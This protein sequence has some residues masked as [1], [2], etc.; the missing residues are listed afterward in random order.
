MAF[1]IKYLSL[2]KAEL[3]YEVE[4]RGG[5]GSTVQELRRQIVK[6]SQE[7]PSEDILESHLEPSDDLKVV[8]ESLLKSQGNLSS[9]KSKFDKNLLNRTETLLNHLYHRLNRI[10]NVPEVTDL[11][12]TCLTSFNAQYKELSA[13]KPPTSQTKPTT[14]N[15]TD[16]ATEGPTISVTCE[17]NLSSDI[18]K[19]KYSG[20]SCV[21]SFILKVEEFVLSRGI[22]YD[23]IL[24]LAFEIFTDDALHWYR[25]NKDK[26]QSWSELCKLLIE[27]FSSRDYDYRFL[28]EIRSR[29]QGE[30]E[31]IT[32]Y[33]SIMH[34]M[35]SRL[36]KPLSEDDKLEI[37][38][39]NIRPCYANTLSASP[40]I[41]TIDSLKS[42]CRNYEN[43]QSR[44]S[45]FHEPPKVSSCTIAPE[46]AYKPSTSAS[47][48]LPNKY[49]SFNQH[50]HTYNTDQNNYN[51]PYSTTNRQ[52]PTA[53]YYEN[54]NIPV[55]VVA[56]DNPKV[57]FCP[58]CRTDDHSLKNCK[59]DRFLICF[60]CGK[61]DVRFSECPVCNP[62]SH[63]PSKN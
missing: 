57:T 22:S 21:R 20:K 3:E 41:L 33:L 42:L 39:H 16:V 25:Y 46:F 24:S 48:S 32:I 62:F 47:N 6:L 18:C 51:K 49:N 8:K 30:S 40:D 54:K 14:S 36:S 17:R 27:D 13:L 58:R 7:M 1:S 55:S 60:K 2:Q 10:V 45:Q 43:I 11:Y 34:G 44:F 56:R 37:I 5:V 50:K 4:L 12:K 23:K 63:E 31:N 15:T 9:L 61:K 28:S 59:E 38:L 52:K 29:T 19:L 26:V 53:N 35:F